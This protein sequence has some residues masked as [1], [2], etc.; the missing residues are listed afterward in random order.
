MK[1]FRKRGGY[2]RL[3]ITND[4]H[5]MVDIVCHYL[6]HLLTEQRVDLIIN[7]TKT[8]GV[9]KEVSLENEED[10]FLVFKIGKEIKKIPLLDDTKARFGKEIAVL[11][12]KAHTTVIELL[13]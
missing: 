4:K 3:N 2:M 13:D 12:T 9:I 6:A 11:E 5:A 1:R 10:T 7:G 8:T